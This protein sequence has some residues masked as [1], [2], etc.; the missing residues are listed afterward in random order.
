MSFS[1]AWIGRDA[2]LEVLRASLLA[3]A[4]G[5]GSAWALVGEAGVGKSELASRVAELADER[6]FV[7]SWGRA[8][9]TGG[10]PSLWPWTEVLRGLDLTRTDERTR[11]WLAPLLPELETDDAS[12]ASAP[13]EARFRLLDAVVR[14]LVA[15]AK[16]R[17][18]L[19]VVEDLHAGDPAS[20]ELLELAAS[21]TRNAGL[22][23]VGTWRDDE[24]R[25][26]SRALRR[27]SLGRFTRAE[28]AE[29]V[30]E[31]SWVEP[32]MHATEGYPL[33]LAEV[34]RGLSR[35]E[36]R[37]DDDRLVGVPRSVEATLRA[38]LERLDPTVCRVVRTAAVWGRD[39][40]VTRVS[41]LAELEPPAVE[42]ALSEA[43]EAAIVARVPQGWRFRHVLWRDAVLASGD[44]SWRRSLHERAATWL[45]AR[46]EVR[47]S[48]VAHQL[49]AAGVRGERLAEAAVRAAGA[50]ME[51][52]AHD[53][54]LRW[55]QHAVEAST[56]ERARA[57]RLVAWADTA[58]RAGDLRGG[59][60]MA[61]RA[62]AIARELGDTPLFARAALAYGGEIV[63][64]EVDATLIALLEEARD[65]LGETEPALVA[66]VLA[67]LASALQPAPDPTLPFA[68][69]REAIE[70]AR[71]LGDD[72]VLLQVFRS[73]NAAFVDL[74]PPDERLACDREHA[75]LAARR[76]D[77]VEMHR[78]WRRLHFDA[79]ELGD[80]GLARRAVEEV[81]ACGE[82]LGTPHFVWYGHALA[83]VDHAHRGDHDEVRRA[84]DD[85]R[86]AADS[87][88]SDAAHL[89]LSYQRVL[90]A[91]RRGALDEA[92]SEL[93]GVAPTSRFGA[94][95]VRLL[96]ASVGARRRLLQG[97]APIVFP[98]A[99]DVVSRWI[100]MG[101]RSEMHLFA[102][103]AFATEDAALAARVEE[104]LLPYAAWHVSFGLYAMY[105]GG[106][107]ARDLALLAWTRGDVARAWTW[108][109]RAAAEAE[110][111]EARVEAAWIAVERARW[112]SALG[113][114][115]AAA[116]ARD[117]R[118][119]AEDVGL[120]LGELGDLGG[121]ERRTK[122]SAPA[123]IA[124]A[125]S[126]SL[127][128]EGEVWRVTHDARSFVLADTK[129]TRWLA[130]L[131]AA[132]GEELHVLDLASDTGE[133]APGSRSDAGEVLDA[134]ARR[135]YAA[136]ARA[137]R[138]RL[139][140][141]EERSDLGATERAQEELHALERELRAALGLGGRAR[142]AGATV[143]KARVNVQRRL[144]D[145]IRRVAEQDVVLG[146]HLERSIRTGILCAYEPDGWSVTV[147]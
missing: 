83:A 130:R 114:E 62:A 132:A 108:S 95:F 125:P 145:A 105:A 124:P 72:D 25:R 58:L 70:R 127:V 44:P 74:A 32:V 50:S 18:L 76:D 12:L 30:D 82:R 59:R 146:K 9:E 111:A 5:R 57:E 98:D 142:R 13:V 102:E 11:R 2:E 137:L 94:D 123:S 31:P 89:A 96:G 33:L 143:E 136:R 40:D 29:R 45:R 21:A 60:A 107:V 42:A 69:A 24:E 75:T 128:R 144:K 65:A 77:P 64:A 79:R 103:L 16:A 4:E 131:A 35:G 129:G 110:R 23:L 115:D 84:Q 93:R 52:F 100:S 41:A 91:L 48:E 134:K 85:A 66:L 10:A 22:M 92:E 19:V 97:A 104:A 27:L 119:R 126:W 117:A 14:T 1:A 81:R 135:A 37:V 38:R 80:T 3:T 112:A 122:S 67:R 15:H 106:P 140:E 61:A 139:E 6:D 141:A 49:L 147:R 116:R 46:P 28:V 120:L 63:A 26:A 56:D 90:W 99:H 113:R 53:D 87:A 43:A 109:E 17:P 20:L 88:R 34:L 8:V 133:A 73:A 47:W 68:L 78:A 118:E 51:R 54:A 86:R 71:A 39:I 7:V 101:D 138:E 55:W 36:L 121:A